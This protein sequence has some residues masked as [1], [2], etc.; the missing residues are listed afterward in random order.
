MYVRITHIHTLSTSKKNGMPTT[1][2]I[3]LKTIISV[4]VG[5]FADIDSVYIFGSRR[6]KTESVRSDIDLLIT[7]TGRIKQSDLRDYTLESCT[8]LDLF[9]L[10]DN[11]ATSIANE[12]FISDNTQT[13]LLDKLSAVKLYERDTSFTEEM[14]SYKVMPLDRRVNHK[15]SSLPNLSSDAYEIQAL[16]KYFETANRKGLPTKPYIG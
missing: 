12:S 10:D 6:Y 5:K 1:D 11:K 4:L 15:L 3:D 13:L 14:E 8:A 2:D 16:I 7:T 9:L